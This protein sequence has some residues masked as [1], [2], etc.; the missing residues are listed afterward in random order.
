MSARRSRIDGVSLVRFQ[1]AGV[2]IKADTGYGVVRRMSA[3]YV[4]VIRSCLRFIRAEQDVGRRNVNRRA[5]GLLQRIEAQV[6]RFQNHSRLR[7]QYIAATR[8]LRQQ[9]ILC[10]INIRRVGFYARRNEVLHLSVIERAVI[11]SPIVRIGVRFDGIARIVYRKRA[12]LCRGTISARS[13]A[14]YMQG[15]RRSD[16]IEHVMSYHRQ[17]S[18]RSPMHRYIG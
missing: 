9:K 2:L 8:Y 4:A 10:V 1:R 16:F 3:E 15:R 17:I 13:P 11:G 5:I 12:P 14:W 6:P 7:R 18:D